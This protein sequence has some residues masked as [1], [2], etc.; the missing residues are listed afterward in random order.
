VRMMSASTSCSTSLSGHRPR[1]HGG[2]RGD[3]FPFALSTTNSP[4]V[5]RKSAW[6]SSRTA[7]CFTVSKA[8]I[9]NQLRSAAFV[10]QHAG[11]S[12][13]RPGAS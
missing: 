3:A 9:V 11:H 1:P 5:Q 4:P 12:E 8:G 6:P 7:S 13:S 2:G 10:Q